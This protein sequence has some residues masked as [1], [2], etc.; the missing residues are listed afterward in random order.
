MKKVLVIMLVLLIGGIGYLQ[1]VKAPSLNLVKDSFENYFIWNTDSDLP[2]DPNNPGNYVN[3]EIKQSSEK[4]KTG[5]KSICLFI[6][7]HQDDGTIWFEKEITVQKNAEIKVDLSFELYSPSESFNTI[8]MVVGCIG[9]DNPEYEA[10]FTVLGSANMVEGW[11][12]YTLSETVTTDESGKIC[13]GVG[14]SVRWEAE[15]QYYI[16]DVEIYISK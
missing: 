15:M 5:S 12:K 16:D 4:A 14:I 1:L 10:D 2:L 8:A 13:V 7:G 3:W 11:K 9:L 6:D